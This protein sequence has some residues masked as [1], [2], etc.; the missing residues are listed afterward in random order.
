MVQI[1]E[2]KSQELFLV[3]AESWVDQLFQRRISRNCVRVTLRQDGTVEE[4]VRSFEILLGQTQG[5]SE[6]PAL[7]FFL[8]GLREDIKG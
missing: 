4:F 7:G 5:L 6:E 2:R 8:A 1:L 3:W